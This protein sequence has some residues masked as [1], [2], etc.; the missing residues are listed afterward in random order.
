MHAWPGLCWKRSIGRITF[1]SGSGVGSWSKSLAA[2]L[3]I[4]FH[5]PYFWLHHGAV[6]VH[7]LQFIGGGYTSNSTQNTQPNTLQPLMGT[8]IRGTGLNAVLKQASKQPH[9]ASTWHHQ[10]HLLNSTELILHGTCYHHQELL[11]FMPSPSLS[12][13]PL[14]KAAPWSASQR[15]ARPLPSGCCQQLTGRYMLWKVRAPHSYWHCPGSYA[16]SLLHV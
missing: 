2:L 6:S 16:V 15:K 13:F 1:H 10:H 9:M 8:C 5:I 7:R 4:L 14:I 3:P 11:F 12:S